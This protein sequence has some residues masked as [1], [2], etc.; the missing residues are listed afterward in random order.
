[1]SRSNKVSSWGRVLKRSFVFNEPELSVSVACLVKQACLGFEACDTSTCI[2][3]HPRA[4]QGFSSDPTAILTPGKHPEPL[5]FPTQGRP[6]A[7]DCGFR[8][9]SFLLLQLV[10][11][12][13]CK[14]WARCRLD[15]K[16]QA[17]LQRLRICQCPRAPSR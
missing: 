14:Q 7:R 16:T 6:K 8:F 13:L 10:Q 1:M 4:F 11:A 3:D 5:I 15:S 2:S 17:P 9:L 12:W